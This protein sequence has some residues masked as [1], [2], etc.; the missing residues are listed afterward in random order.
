MMHDD[1]SLCLHCNA[2]VVGEHEPR[3]VLATVQAELA[4]AKAETEGAYR[5][6][7][8]LLRDICLALKG[9]NPPMGQHDWSDLPEVARA[10]V[11]ERD[12]LREALQRVRNDGYAPLS[13]TTRNTVD[14]A[15]A[16]KVHT[17]K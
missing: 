17:K 6:F 9:P 8:P 2:Y 12:K 3:C 14:A 16:A 10:L 13:P 1:K 15:L 4:D 7:P 5:L 11:A